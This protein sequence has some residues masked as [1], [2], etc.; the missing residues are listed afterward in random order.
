MFIYQWWYSYRSTH[1]VFK[2]TILI[3]DM[4]DH[5]SSRTQQCCSLDGFNS[6]S[7]FFNP[8]ND[9][10]V[11]LP[12]APIKIGITVTLRFNSFYSSLARSRYS[13]FF[14]LSFSLTLCSSRTAKYTIRLVVYRLSLT[15]MVNPLF[16]RF[17]FFLIITWSGRLADIRWS[18]C[19]SESQIICV[20]VIF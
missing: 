16:S 1:R 12:S 19:I 2:D 11:T 14:L 9:P 7:M 6:S 8:Y 18:V 10:L 20:C 5:K 17:F 13:S 4:N 15:G 3:V